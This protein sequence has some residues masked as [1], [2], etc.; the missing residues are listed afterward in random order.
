MKRKAAI[1]ILAIAQILSPRFA[2]PQD[3]RSSQAP[4][5]Q[6]TSGAGPLCR[7][8][9]TDKVTITCAYTA[10]SSVDADS[11]TNPRIILNRVVISLIPSD[12]KPMH[13]ELTFTDGRG[14]RVADQRTV[15]LSI[16]D[17]KGENHM[18]RPLPGVDFS[19]L[20]PGKPMKFQETLFAPAFSAGQYVVSLWIP[21]S[22]SSLKFDPAHNFLL[23]SQGVPDRATGLNRLA[24]FAAA[25]ASKS[26]GG[27]SK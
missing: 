26:K 23:S 11:R 20:E 27:K 24:E 14:T 9:G 25:P 10:G 12:G 6:D 22:V 5:R 16:D 8:I 15:Y 4:T 19:K 18:R 21:S 13:V 3:L 7:T 1:S 2:A 17:E